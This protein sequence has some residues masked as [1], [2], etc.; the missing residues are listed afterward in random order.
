MQAY[1]QTT[2]PSVHQMVVKLEE[3]GLISKIPYTPRSIKILIPPDQIPELGV[4]VAGKV[5]LRRRIWSQASY[6]KAFRFAAE[7]HKGQLFP[8]T[9]LP[10]IMHISFVGM[11][12]MACLDVEKKHDGD[13]AV[14]CAL[15]H[16]VLED[17]EITCS[18]VEK[19]FGAKVAQGVLAL[20][21]DYSLAPE[22]K[23]PDSLTRIRKQPHEIWMVKLADRITNL[24]PPPYYWKMEKIER[25][26]EEA[27]EIHRA[28]HEASAYLSKRL[29]DKIDEYKMY[30]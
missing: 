14:Q 23:M 25:Y 12:I 10:Y 4:E 11:E 2:A 21:K 5:N 6:L 27:L 3:K 29:A 28:L 22:Q 1:F 15:L 9:D 16:D 13:L 17:T 18:E 20:T 24:A 19:A 26:R 30:L 8:G 7:A